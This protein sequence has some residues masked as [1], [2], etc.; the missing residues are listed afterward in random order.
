ML[1]VNKISSKK[2][3]KLLKMLVV[4]D[5]L[6]NGSARVVYD[7]N[8]SEVEKILGVTFPTDIVIKLGCG[9]AGCVQ[10]QIE[11]NTYEAHEECGALAAIYGY[12]RFILICEKVEVYDIRELDEYV[13]YEDYVDSI[14]SDLRYGA[15]SEYSL[16]EE[17]YDFVIGHDINIAKAIHALSSHGVNCN[18]DILQLGLTRDG[19]I[20]CF[21][22]GLDDDDFESCIGDASF[23]VA[24]NSRLYISMCSASWNKKW[25]KNKFFSAVARLV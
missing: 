18:A 23:D 8:K 2:E 10:N 6:G 5:V 7:V 24:E 19:R 20:V 1:L 9:R 22:Y 16:C 25:N 12:G 21:D 11:I 15:D 4:A 17:L 13:D 14:V 3:K